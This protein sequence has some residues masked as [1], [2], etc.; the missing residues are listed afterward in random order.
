MEESMEAE[1]FE[2]ADDHN[3]NNTW[4]ASPS[5]Y[6]LPQNHHPEKTQFLSG[7]SV[8]G[9]QTPP[10]KPQ[11][12]SLSG[13]P[14]PDPADSDSDPPTA[15]KLPLNMNN[16]TSRFLMNVM[17]TED[18]RNT[19]W[20][21]L[22]KA[23]DQLLLQSPVDYIPISYEQIYSCVYKCVC[24]QHSEI[25]YNDLI[26]KITTYLERVSDELQG[27]PLENFIEKFDSALTRY[28]A[29]LQSI[30]PIFIYM[31][32]FYIETKLNR[33]LKD[34]LI[35][36]FAWHVAEKHI[37]TLI[38]LLIKA[39]STPFQVKP[40]T[41]ASVV[42]GLYTLRPDWVRLAPL[43]FSSFI[44][45]INPPAQECELPDYAAQDRRLQAELSLNGFARG[46]QSR[47]RAG[48]DLTYNGSSS[49][50]PNS[51]GCR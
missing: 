9:T 32:K 25:M 36:L 28:M 46:D 48:E 39:H 29:A 10:E 45:Q 20:P 13:I 44:P 11:A 24:Q 23:I 15:G 42:K 49:P 22:E 12:G 26:R 5:T 47:K 8:L 41:M 50:C 3:H 14:I 1:S 17:T 18:Y 38:P 34:D 7:S 6:E 43:L 27:C 16:T 31:N 35:Q 51:R 40:S 19:Y 21:K 2:I 30:V 4:E 37:H 33:D